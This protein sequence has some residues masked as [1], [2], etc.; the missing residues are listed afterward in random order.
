[1]IDSRAAR[2]AIVATAMA[3]TACASSA[4]HSSGASNPATSAQPTST[5]LTSAR[6]PRTSPTSTSPISTSSTSA[7]QTSTSLTSARPTQTISTSASAGPFSTT[8]PRP[9]APRSSAPAP[10]H[11]TTPPPSPTE[12]R[13]G[14]ARPSKTPAATPSTTS[15][16]PTAVSVCAA[17][18]LRLS[19]GVPDPGAG[20]MHYPVYLRNVGKTC[21]MRGYPGFSI[22][23]KNGHIIGRPATRNHGT[24]ARTVTLSKGQRATFTVHGVNGVDGAGCPSN[25][26]EGVTMQV[27]P[28]N[29]TTA[30]RLSDHF[31]ACDLDV[32][33]VTNI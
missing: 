20:N 31:G 29:Q 21:T 22:L 3:L 25:W 16:I 5:G 6:L 26:T 30:L 19:L 17:A 24:T 9:S 2:A 1:M 10:A 32:T 12:T 23:D 18:N 11:R 27:F 4:T 14:R 8:P 13:S 33:P 15:A 28:P 7:G